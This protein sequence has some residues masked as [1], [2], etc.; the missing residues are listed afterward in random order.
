MTHYLLSIVTL[1]VIY[2]I[3]SM[4]LNV[5]WGWAGEFDFFV[6]GLVALGAY[7]DAVVTL[8]P[9]GTAAS[10]LVYILGWK[11][12][13]IVG[14]LAAMLVGGVVS[15]LVGAIALRQLRQIYFAIVTFSAVL[16]LAA[17]VG[18][19]TFLFN[20]FTG[21]FGVPQPFASF[22]S[23]NA[24]PWLFLAL[25][26][27]VLIV[28]YIVLERI[29]WSPYGLMLRA[30]RED[31]VAA[32]AFGYNPYTQRL[33]AYVLGG[34]VAGLAGSL[35]VSYLTVFN[36]D[37]WTPIETVLVFAALIIGGTGN[38]RGAIVG[39]FLVFGLIASTTQFLPSVP[40]NPDAPSALRTISI[41]LILLA[42]LRWRPQGIFPERHLRSAA[43]PPSGTA[44]RSMRLVR[45]PRRAG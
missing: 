14:V 20:G 18:Q 21:V 40:G 22:V 35:L 15:L 12:P 37:A 2:S 26:V 16:I 10:G 31:E 4:A 6:Y 25:A 41:G 45:R 7:V 44:L 27:A 33:K 24:Y 42:F 5:R 19:E 29:F 28:V 43:A 30:I 38:G 3:V 17:I 13:V 1:A 11:M 36:T 9:S 23:A 39:A 8:P 34:V 32:A